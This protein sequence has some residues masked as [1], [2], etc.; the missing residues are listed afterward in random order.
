MNNRKEYFKK[1]YT[2][3]KER[4]AEWGKEYRIKNKDKIAKRMKV[5]SENNK[6][7]IA[8]KNRQRYLRDKDI[9]LARTKRWQKENKEKVYK[10][11]KEWKEKNYEHYRMV[12][13]ATSKKWREKN[14]DKV[15][16][17]RYTSRDKLRSDVLNAYGNKCKCCGEATRQFL[18]IDHINNDGAKHK[19]DNN[20]KSAQAFYT[21][22]RTN[23]YPKDNF[24]ILCHNCNMAKGFYG[25]C[26]HNELIHRAA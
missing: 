22:L 1:Y 26:P 16:A 24:Q 5:Y 15:Q 2:I 17:N 20:L 23:N 10:K 9:I 8:E 19:R 14:I 21:W 3:N 13:R 7:K 18:C 4:H 25:A 11:Q 12:M 6:E